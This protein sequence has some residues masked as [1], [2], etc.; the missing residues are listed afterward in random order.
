MIPDIQ[1]QKWSLHIILISL[2]TKLYFWILFHTYMQCICFQIY[3]K[4]S[5]SYIEYLTI[6]GLDI[7]PQL[8]G[9]TFQFP[10]FPIIL[11]TRLKSYSIPQLKSTL[12]ITSFPPN[13]LLLHR[14]T[15]LQS[16]PTMFSICTYLPVYVDI[17]WTFIISQILQRTALTLINAP[18]N[19]Q[20][21][22]FL[23]V[24]IISKIRGLWLILLYNIWLLLF[25][26]LACFDL[27]LSSHSKEEHNW[28][29]SQLI[30]ESDNFIIH[31]M[32]YF[33]ILVREIFVD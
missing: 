31:Y 4:I 27:W 26:L 21:L 10:P 16:F 15:I 11:L 8:K 18:I 2:N 22:E 24:I 9:E 12:S 14:L 28:I 5:I 3:F 7:Y 19:Q 13:I 29:I 6:W 33:I 17:A 30:E 20:I 23:W 25:L 1:F 32:L